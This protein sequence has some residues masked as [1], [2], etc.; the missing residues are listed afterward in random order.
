MA[1]SRGKEKRRELREQ[2]KCKDEKST[3]IAAILYLV[4]KEVKTQEIE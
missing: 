1:S 3:F 2:Q 4:A